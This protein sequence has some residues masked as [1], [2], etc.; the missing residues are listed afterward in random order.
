MAKEIQHTFQMTNKPFGI[1]LTILPTITPV[2][3][4][5]Y[6]QVIVESGV[7]V[8]ETGGHNPQPHLPAFAPPASR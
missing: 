2:P 4:D 3:Y 5:E 7:K 8:V 6:R 1:N